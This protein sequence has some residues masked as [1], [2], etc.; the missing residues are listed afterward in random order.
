MPVTEQTKPVCLFLCCVS[1][2]SLLFLPFLIHLYCDKCITL[3][4]M[5]FVCSVQD[6]GNRECKYLFLGIPVWK[7]H[8][9]D[10]PENNSSFLSSKMYIYSLKEKIL[11]P[12]KE[13]TWMDTPTSAWCLVGIGELSPRTQTLLLPKLAEVLG[14]YFHWNL[15]AESRCCFAFDLCNSV[16]WPKTTSACNRWSDEMPLYNNKYIWPFDGS[17]K[18]CITDTG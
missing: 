18:L 1:P 4:Y 11:V 17:V 5:S 8:T 15:K 12:I 16:G 9:S 7:L 14:L 13:L 10:I 6:P 2:C 3:F